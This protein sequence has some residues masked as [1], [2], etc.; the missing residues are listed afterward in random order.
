M[1]IKSEYIPQRVIILLCIL[2]RQLQ[3]SHKICGITEFA[4]SVTDFRM[5][6]ARGLLIIAR[7]YV[8][9]THF[10][11]NS[12]VRTLGYFLQRWPKDCTKKSLQ[13]VAFLLYCISSSNYG[14]R[15]IKLR[16]MQTV[17]K[18][19]EKIAIKLTFQLLALAI[20]E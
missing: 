5:I 4:I 13:I 1:E 18:N 12:V 6:I 20:L 10:L 11:H 14:A 7:A 17:S 16:F 3:T 8:N 9:L 19:T 2:C 15:T